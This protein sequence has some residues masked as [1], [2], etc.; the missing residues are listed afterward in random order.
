M[1]HCSAMR[2]APLRLASPLPI[3]DELVNEC[4]DLDS[5][6]DIRFSR[7]WHEPVRP[8]P[9]TLRAGALP[10]ITGHIAESVVELVLADYQY[11]PLE[12]HVGPGR[13]GADLIMLNLTA[14]LV[15]VIEVKGTL[16][17]GHV[18][19]LTSGELAQ[20]S[21]GW[22]DK[23]DNPAM[24]SAGLRS[25]DVYGAVMAVNFA[26]MTLR[27]IVTADF[28]ALSPVMRWEELD[29]PSWLRVS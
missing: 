6:L 29:D 23:P 8:L 19:R 16:R 5:E 27:A 12:H 20:M 13:H 11:V 18:P 4:L 14:D 22:L 17:P 10:G 25:E 26:D 28:I 2:P 7:A 21:A 9:S 15:L 3:S 24:V 1:W